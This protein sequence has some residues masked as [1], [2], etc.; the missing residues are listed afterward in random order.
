[1]LIIQLQ[2]EIITLQ[3]ENRELERENDELKRSRRKRSRSRSPRRPQV[4]R[5]AIHLSNM[6]AVVDR[7]QLRKE[8]EKQYGDLKE[9]TISRDGH[10]ARVV[11]HSEEKQRLCLEE[12]G[13]WEEEYP[14]LK[15][16]AHITRR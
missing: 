1:M 5:D 16:Q 13:Y 6:A 8:F 2:S 4:S 3:R 9:F 15:L 12:A 10:W 7:D 14:G 11:F